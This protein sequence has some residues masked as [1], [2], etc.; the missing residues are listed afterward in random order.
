MRKI[1]IRT[2]AS[3]SIKQQVRCVSFVFIV[4][5]LVF[6]GEDESSRRADRWVGTW[7]A[8]PQTGFSAADF[9]NQTLRMVVH[10][11][12]GGDRLRVRLSNAFGSQPLVIT[13]MH[14]GTRSA[15]AALVVGS[16]RAV[17]FS[18]RATVTIPP[19][20]LEVSDAV[21]LAVPARS[22]LA[23]SIFLSVNAGPATTHNLLGISYVAPGD[24]TASESPGPYTEVLPEWFFLTGVE[25]SASKHIDEAIVAFGDSITDGAGSTPD[26]NSRWPDVLA[27]RL[28]S[29]HFRISTLNEGIAGNCILHDCIGPNA[30]ARFDRDVLSQTEVRFVIVLEGI[31]DIG[32]SSTLGDLTA[33]E[34]IAGLTQLVRRA[35]A[36]DLKVFGATL[37]PF[38]GTTIP[39]YFSLQGEMKREA[40]NEFIRTSGT[41]DDVIDF[42]KV[43]RDP[44][45]PTQLLP[46]Y[47]SGD[48][49]HPND[50]GYKAMGGAIDLSLFGIDGE[51]DR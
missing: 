29:H 31:N 1:G 33:N 8:S 16:D 32:T 40:V 5:V 15:G 4:V 18:G 27:R 42:D 34:I 25:V 26:S 44:S 46:A 2:I 36:K 51:G 10:T 24:A 49:L 17:T 28:I 19:G 12:V 50:A 9:N 45:H 21:N 38:E 41:F 7:S 3:D 23:V 43:V 30:L 37:T 47:D 48:H 39:N 35:H 13:A 22:D 20:A 6:A 14:V 11:S